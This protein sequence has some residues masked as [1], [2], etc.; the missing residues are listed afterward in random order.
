MGLSSGFAGDSVFF[1][2]A[3]FSTG[4]A[5]SLFSLTA[6]VEGALS[7]ERT[8]LSDMVGAEGSGFFFGEEL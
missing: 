4:F 5:D 8:S 3:G 1:S 7:R 6:L 2:A